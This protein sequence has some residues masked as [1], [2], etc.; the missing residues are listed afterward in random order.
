MPWLFHVELLLENSFFLLLS[1]HPRK[2][3][4][5]LFLIRITLCCNDLFIH[6]G[7]GI[8]RKRQVDIDYSVGKCILEEILWVK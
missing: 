5:S 8:E 7:L 3:S 2:I 1:S 6:M 4:P